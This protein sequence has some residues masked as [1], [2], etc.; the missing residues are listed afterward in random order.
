MAAAQIVALPEDLAGFRI[1][2]HH[3]CAKQA[4]AV[5]RDAAGDAAGLRL[6]AGRRI[7]IRDAGDIVDLPA[8]VNLAREF[9]ARVLDRFLERSRVIHTTVAAARGSAYERLS[10]AAPP[11]WRRSDTPRIL[12]SCRN[13]LAVSNSRS[14][15]PTPPG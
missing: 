12:P 6:L 9:G 1:E 15:A 11:Y 3:V 10:I 14:A 5:L 7:E 13:H 8:I 4:L 2:G